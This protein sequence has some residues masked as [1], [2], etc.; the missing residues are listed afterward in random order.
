MKSLCI[1]TNS[2]DIVIYLL[3][4]FSSLDNSSLKVSNRKF[5]IYENVILHFD[6]ENSDYFYDQ[7]STI[8]T[9]CILDFFQ[10]KLLKRIL[11]YNYF[12][13]SSFEKKHIIKLGNDFL[14]SDIVSS[15]DNFFSIYYAIYDYIFTNKSIVLDGFVNFRLQNYMKNLDYIIDISVNKYLIEKEYHEFVSILKLYVSMTPYNSPLIHL[16]YI[17]NESV[18]L[19]KDKNII[20]T[21]DDIFKAK[22]LSDISF[23][24]NDYALNTLLNLTPKKLIIHLIDNNKEDEFIN[25]LKLI[26]ENRIELCTDCNICSTFKLSTSHLQN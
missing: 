23:S 18:L 20:S 3:D 24:S 12:Y 16:I 11:E 22:Y 13:F 5:K 14:E 6:D 26:F 15:E 21:E 19:D 9:N 1:K 17:N 8:L 4:K 25:T 7:I 2:N 10:D